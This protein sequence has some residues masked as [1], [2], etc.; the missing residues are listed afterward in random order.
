MD[1]A[2]QTP[3]GS[4]TPRD[5]RK[6]RIPAVTATLPDGGRLEMVFDR[7]AKTTGFARYADG[8]WTIVPDQKL[9]GGRRLVPYSPDNN[10]LEHGVVRFPSTPAE[11]GD[12]AALRESIRGFIHAHVSVSSG[13]ERIATSYVLLTWLFDTFNEL[14]Y[15]RVRGEPGSGKTR[16]LLIVGALCYRPIFASGA[17]SVSP[18]FRILDAMQ[19]TL[20]LDESDFRFSDERADVVKILNN[21][22]VRG[23]PV[24]RTESTQGGREFNPR[25][26]AVYGPKIVASRGSF[27]DPALESR[28][29]TEQMDPHA[30]RSGIPINLAS[31]WERE[32]LRIRNMLL[33]YRFRHMESGPAAAPVLDVTLEP[34]LRQI[35]GPLYGVTADEETRRDLDGLLREYDVEMAADR[36]LDLEALV[37]GIADEL[38]RTDGRPPA[39]KAIADQFVKVHGRQYPQVSP[40][41][42]GWILRRRLGL[43]TQ[44]SNGRFVIAF[45]EEA[46]FARLCERYGVTRLGGEPRKE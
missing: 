40:K 29:L 7:E 23:F 1:N 9:T 16:F 36:G 22:N 18:L 32:A 13:F 21:G 8:S 37:L 43:R 31:D 38:W 39:V 3:S 26:F 2:P 17:S 30:L 28:F 6:T 20:I 19:G 15:L 12:V 4:S 11:Y 41:R 5:D 34:R 42:A 45:G 10:L 44:K 27:D 46:R 14:P 35:F 25:A 24:L 33:L